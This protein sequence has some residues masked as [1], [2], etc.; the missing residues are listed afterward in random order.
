MAIAIYTI[1]AKKLGWFDLSDR[2]GQ[3]ILW[4]VINALHNAPDWRLQISLAMLISP[5]HIFNQLVK[6]FAPSIL[7]PHIFVFLAVFLEVEKQY[8]RSKKICIFL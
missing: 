1:K 3:H 8:F 5:V 2:D 4:C 7:K 6:R